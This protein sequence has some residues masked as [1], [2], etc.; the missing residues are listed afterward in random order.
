MR[1][2]IFLLIF[3]LRKLY[4]EMKTF[5]TDL[6]SAFENTRDSDIPAQLAG[7]PA[8]MKNRQPACRLHVMIIFPLFRKARV[9]RRRARYRHHPRPW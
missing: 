1:L 2:L 3:D 8:C 5:S 7:I 4:F 9:F 6:D